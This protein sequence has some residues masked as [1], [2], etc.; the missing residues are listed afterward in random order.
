MILRMESP[1]PPIRVESWV[2]GEPL[3][4]FKLGTLYI[5]EFWATWCGGCGAEI[6]HLAQLQEKYNHSA[7]EV[8]AVAASERGSTAEEARTSLD[9]WLT[10]KGSK[11]KFRIAF[12][13]AGKMKKLWMAPSFSTTIPTS[14]VIDR[15]G[16]VAF[17][18]HPMQLND[19][20]PKIVNGT[21]RTS[22]EAKAADAERIAKAESKMREKARMQAFWGKLGPA[23][24]A[25][26]SSTTLSAAKEGVPVM[27]D[28][29]NVRL[30]H[31]DLLLHKI[32]DMRT[33][34]PVVRQLVGDAIEKQ[35]EL[36]KVQ[37]ICQLSNP[38]EDN[39][40]FPHSDRFAM[41]K[42]LAEHILALNS[43][44]GRGRPKFLSYVAVAQYYFESGNRDRAVEL[45]ESAVKS[46]DGPRPMGAEEKAHYL[47]LLLKALAKYEDEEANPFS[48]TKNALA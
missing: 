15:D 24:K 2:R 23:L 30:V 37:A 4:N 12:D 14:F 9:A 21:W 33:G 22:D 19:V 29:I 32:H 16:H 35:S 36:W 34:L 42:E 40:D 28:D 47:R 46:L 27:P 20:F 18:G 38:A 39:S 45:V 41:S 5:V 8:I 44:E 43:P 17:I 1:A 26:D 3:T 25:Q 31:A 10:E 48:G 7:V 6:P 11:L 13:Y